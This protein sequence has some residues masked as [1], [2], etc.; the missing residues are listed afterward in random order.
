MTSGVCVVSSQDPNCIRPDT[1]KSGCLQCAAKY[2]IDNSTGKCRQVSPLC[3]TFNPNNGACLTCFSGYVISGSTCI[4]S[5]ASNSDSKCQ[6]ISNGTCQKCYSGYFIN[7]NGICTQFNPL[8]KTSDSAN[9]ACLSCYP[10]Y[11]LNNGACQLGTSP[12]TSKDPNCKQADASGI[13][14]SC[15]VGYYLLPNKMCQ[16]M[17]PLCKNYTISLSACS[18]C[19]D[20]YVLNNGQCLLPT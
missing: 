19:Y 10:G 2:F 16:K 1:A 14:S 13:C 18:G 12:T 11:T 7:L 17:D 6:T 15:Y 8:C 9:G 20:G 4:F 3:Q 5:T